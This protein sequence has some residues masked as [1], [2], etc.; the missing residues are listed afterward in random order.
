M[1]ARKCVDQATQDR[2]GIADQRRCRTREA[3]RLL[4][5]G[6]DADDGKLRIHAPLRKAVEQPRAD[7]EHHVGLAPQFAA[8][9]QRDAQRIAAVEHAAAAPIGQHRRL[10]QPRQLGDFGATRPARRRRQRSAAA[11]QRRG[12]WQRRDR[13]FVH[14]G[15]AAGQGAATTARRARCGP[16]RPSRIP[17]PPG[18]DGRSPLRGRPAATNPAAS[19]GSRIRA[20]K[21]TSR[22]MMPAWSRISCR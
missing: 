15:S 18:R 3:F 1:V 16:T 20:E 14:D 12:A 13:V 7:A 19:A 4:G 6:I 22:S 21:S 8:E 2:S 9:R 17:A 5:I 10:Q 11:W